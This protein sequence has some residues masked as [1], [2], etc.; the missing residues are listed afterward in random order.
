MFNQ[1]NKLTPIQSSVLIKYIQNIMQKYEDAGFDGAIYTSSN[2]VQV[3]VIAAGG[4]PYYL[5]ANGVIYLP[6]DIARKIIDGGK[7]DFLI[8]EMAHWVQ[9]EHYI[10]TPAY[11]VQDGKW[12]IETSAENM[13][14][15]IDPAYVSA[16]LAA[17]G[18]IDVDEKT[19]VLQESPYQWPH[20]E[21]YVMAQQVKVNMCT[22]SVCPFSR[23]SFIGIINAGLFPFNDEAAKSQLH[24]NLP[25]YAR[26][27]LGVA[28]EKANTQIS[29]EAVQIGDNYGDQVVVSRTTKSAFDL[30]VN[31][32][33]GRI[34]LEETGTMP[35][36]I[37]QAPIQKDGVYVLRVEVASGSSSP[38]WPAML[39]IEAG[40]PFYY[41]L[42][43]GDVQFN[44]GK[45]EL[46][47]QPIKQGTTGNVISK[48]R[49][50]AIGQ[51]GGEVFKAH[52]SALDLSGM[53][54]IDLTDESS[55]INHLACEDA[56][57]GSVVAKF[58]V[59]IPGMALMFGDFIP[60]LVSNSLVWNAVPARAS[61]IS[62]GFYSS[63]SPGSNYSAVA[64]LEEGIIRLEVT[65]VTPEETTF[66]VDPKNYSTTFI[67]FPGTVRI[68]G[69]FGPVDLYRC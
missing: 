37:I 41:R 59:P 21:S 49:L 3:V 27:L 51:Q 60:D 46:I 10:M 11:L 33:L 43:N 68:S 56:D 7:D 8:H 29:L 23:E 25:D 9:D 65:S 20:D 55:Y 4:T 19:S 57:D 14:M 15:L 63:S 6:S 53:W 67:S 1:A 12:W 28:P 44:D 42:D 48:V 38:D 45:S 22:N 32:G 31:T 13:M 62:G 54:T 17:Y 16:N 36:M 66:D 5:V 34:T 18:A 40:T 24:A 52:L 64:N 50:V 61:A 35:G 2:P 30:R 39:R 69:N 47:I 58:G 26:Y